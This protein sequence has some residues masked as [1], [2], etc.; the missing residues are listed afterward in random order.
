MDYVV[1]VFAMINA[2]AIGGFTWWLVRLGRE[3]PII[4][5]TVIQ[6][7]VRKQDDR[8]EKRV[9]RAQG[10]SEDSKPTEY[11]EDGVGVVAG[12]PMRRR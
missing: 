11:S 10:Q 9:A 5:E 3:Y 8:M 7:E 1:V 12:R 4:V 2:A 6:D